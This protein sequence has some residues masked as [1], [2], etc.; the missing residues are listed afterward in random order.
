MLYL[1]AIKIVLN[2][3]E[4]ITVKASFTLIRKKHIVV[5][6]HMAQARINYSIMKNNITIFSDFS[7]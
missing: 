5:D 2:H 1:I 3:D 7:L 6:S 4:A